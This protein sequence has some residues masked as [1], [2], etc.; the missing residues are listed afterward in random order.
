MFALF[1]SLCST[2][3]IFKFFYFD[4]MRFSIFLRWDLR[5][6]NFLKSILIFKTIQWYEKTCL[7]CERQV[8]IRVIGRKGTLK[9]ELRLK[10][11][12]QKINYKKVFSYYISYEYLVYIFWI[13]YKDRLL[14]SYMDCSIKIWRFSSNKWKYLIIFLHE[15]HMVD[16]IF[17]A[18]RSSS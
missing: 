14:K 2:T 17:Y 18:R 5:M 6:L 16:D 1:Q 9:I 12:W 8:K 7:F 15:N 10:S 4:S 11:Q 13:F 3:A